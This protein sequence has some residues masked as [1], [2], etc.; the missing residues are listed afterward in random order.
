MRHPTI[1]TGE[2]FRSRLMKSYRE[3]DTQTLTLTLNQVLKELKQVSNPGWAARSIQ[4]GLRPRN[5]WGVPV[6]DIRKIAKRIGRDHSL[7]QELWDSKIHEAMI[8]ACMID[9]P[10]LVTEKQLEEWVSGFDSWDVCDA[11]C[12]NLFD[13]SKYAYAKAVEWSSREE[14]FV[15]RAGFAL[16][17]SLAVHDKVASDAKFEKFLPII[18]R[19][20]ADTRHF[21]TKAVNWALRQIG[22][23]NFRL[24]GKHER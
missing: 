24:K 13:K 6:P 10:D 4:A 14:E 3:K 22:K 8:L 2:S 20:S 16:M 1:H 21:V 5:T 17:A 12:G 19:A 23:R 11:C 9:V 15:K 7:A 18:A